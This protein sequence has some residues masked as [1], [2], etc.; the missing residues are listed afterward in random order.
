MAMR[1]TR[2]L[3]P[4]WFWL[5][6]HSLNLRPLNL[7]VLNHYLPNLHP[8][9]IRP[10]NSCPPN[11]HLLNFRPIYFLLLN[12]HPLKSHPLPT[13]SQ[14]PAAQPPSSKQLFVARATIHPYEFLPEALWGCS[15]DIMGL[16]RALD[17]DIFVFAEPDHSVSFDKYTFDGHDLQRILLP[18][19]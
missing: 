2:N 14:P 11:F 12:L 19:D 15:D 18:I 8:L 10:F 17:R 9:I 1:Q 4:R 16:T 3:S 7:R 13:S 6:L 5:N